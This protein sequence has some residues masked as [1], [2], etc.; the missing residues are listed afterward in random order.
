MTAVLDAATAQLHATARKIDH[1]PS[2]ETSHAR[3][4]AE[5]LRATVVSAAGDG[6]YPYGARLRPAPLAFDAQHA[7]RVA[8]LEVFIRQ[9]HSERDLAELGRLVAD[10]RPP[11]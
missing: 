9:H 2:D 7:Q 11:P 10:Q 3:R 5:S 8:D 6:C 4:D 1:D